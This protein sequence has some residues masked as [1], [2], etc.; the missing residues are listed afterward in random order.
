MPP[1]LAVSPRAPR[2][3]W[4][5]EQ[6]ERGDLD[7]VVFYVPPSDHL[8]G[9]YYPG[10]KEY[11]DERGVPSL[12]LREDVLEEAGR[13]TIAALASEFVRGLRPAARAT[14]REAAR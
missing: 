1:A 9:W 10:L 6:V 14:A 12:L 4:L 2:E 7:G 13:A 5:R 3:A 8:F 11:L